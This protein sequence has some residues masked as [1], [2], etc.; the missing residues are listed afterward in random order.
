[1]SGLRNIICRECGAT[2]RTD[3]TDPCPGLCP[4]CFAAA[5][6]RSFNGVPVPYTSDP[7]ERRIIVEKLR[8]IGM[9][10]AYIESMFGVV[11]DMEVQ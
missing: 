5:M 8:A 10:K 11:D 3:D 4:L 6:G 2:G 7:A 1:M 9:T